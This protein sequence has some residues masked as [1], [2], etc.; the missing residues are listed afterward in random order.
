MQCDKTTTLADTTPRDTTAR[1]SVAGRKDATKQS[2]RRL[3]GDTKGFWGQGVSSSGPP[4]CRDLKPELTN[5][6]EGYSRLNSAAW[7]IVGVQSLHGSPLLQT[8]VLLDPG[9]RERWEA[10]RGEEEMGA[11]YS[12]TRH[13]R[14]GVIK[15]L[16]K[17]TVQKLLCPPKRAFN[18]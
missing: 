9:E 4:P 16:S 17:S 7:F 1:L 3:C 2:Q 12:N 15:P 10:Q 13:P 18:F 5:S 6:P 11:V 14:L 8:C